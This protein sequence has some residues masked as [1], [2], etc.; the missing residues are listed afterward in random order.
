ARRAG[1]AG[2]TWRTSP[3]GSASPPTRPPGAPA[4]VRVRLAAAAAWVD[5]GSRAAG[6][7]GA[8]LFG[9]SEEIPSVKARYGLSTPYPYSLLPGPPGAGSAVVRIRA[10]TSRADSSGW[11]CNTRAAVADTNGAATLVPWKNWYPRG[12]MATA[13]SEPGAT[14]STYLPTWDLARRTPSGVIAPTPMTPS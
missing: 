10:A 11:Y 1:P 13:I 3:T 4:T 6:G 14:M 2:P 7:T 8:G 5:P 12:G 9:D